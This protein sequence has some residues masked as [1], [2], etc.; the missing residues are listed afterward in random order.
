VKKFLIRISLFVTVVI[1]VL[2]N[3]GKVFLYH[4]PVYSLVPKIDKRNINGKKVLEQ[5]VDSKKITVI[6]NNKFN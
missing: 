6:E 3:G 5:W 1:F 2:D 4:V